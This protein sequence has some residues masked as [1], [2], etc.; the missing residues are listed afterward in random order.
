MYVCANSCRKFTAVDSY[1]TDLIAWV[2]KLAFITLNI[3]NFPDQNTEC[4]KYKYRLHVLVIVSTFASSLTEA[5]QLQPNYQYNTY[6]S[7]RTTTTLTTKLLV[8]HLLQPKNCCNTTAKL[9]VQH[10]LQPK[11]LLHSLQPNYQYN[12]YHNQRTTT[13]LITTK[14]SKYIHQNACYSG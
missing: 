2:L 1:S 10:L 13:T 11:K 12:A 14:A 7:K 3:L 5:Q 8:Q 4:T 9:L 6:R